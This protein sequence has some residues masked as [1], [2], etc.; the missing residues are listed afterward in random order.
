M[1]D[2]KL[3]KTQLRSNFVEFASFIGYCINIFNPIECDT[4]ASP[5]FDEFRI[6]RPQ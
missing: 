5:L 2:W 4:L 3:V 1:A 6:H